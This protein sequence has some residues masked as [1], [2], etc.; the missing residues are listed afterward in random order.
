MKYVITENPKEKILLKIFNKL[1][2]GVELK[3]GDDRW[4]G[5]YDTNNKLLV[6]HT[7]DDPEIWYFDGTVFS[8]YWALLDTDVKF[9]VDSLKKYIFDK[10]GVKIKHLS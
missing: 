6:G 4:S 8:V 5:F 7:S 9:L 1:F 10:Y 2:D 3:S